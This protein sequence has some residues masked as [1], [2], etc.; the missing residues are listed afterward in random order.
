[1]TAVLP[2]PI[3]IGPGR[4]SRMV[5]GILYMASQ[6][7]AKMPAEP[8]PTIRTS[9]FGIVVVVLVFPMLVCEKV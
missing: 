3:S 6:T 1:M 4:R 7:P 5:K 2:C 8:E 9:V